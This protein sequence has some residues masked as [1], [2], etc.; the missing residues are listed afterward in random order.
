MSRRDS[1]AGD[2]N[3][4]RVQ[5]NTCSLACRVLFYEER[6]RNPLPA[7]GIKN[8]RKIKIPG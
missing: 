6:Q 1:L 8:G 7:A 4:I 3:P 2:T 5:I